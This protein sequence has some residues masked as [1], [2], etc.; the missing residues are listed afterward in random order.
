[1]SSLSSMLA[2]NQERLWG[3]GRPIRA[4]KDM[5]SCRWFR[6]SKQRLC[7]HKITSVSFSVICDGAC[8]MKTRFR[9]QSVLEGSFHVP[10]PIS[11]ADCEVLLSVTAA[12]HR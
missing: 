2:L 3:C 4:P 6:D 11:E 12:H 10:K 1:M 7:D 8:S 9:D 5:D